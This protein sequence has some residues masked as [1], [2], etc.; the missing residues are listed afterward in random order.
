MKIGQFEPKSTPTT[1]A[2]V[3]RKSNSAA[4]TSGVEPSARV[5]LTSTAAMTA[6]AA[7]GSFD[8]AKVERIASAIRDGS[9]QVDA[10]A[11]ADKL[12]ANAQ[13]L[14]SRGTR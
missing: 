5:A 14:L 2:K 12:I 13:E 11:I 6:S 9:Y 10:G 4:D 3:D 7:D 8:V 1:P